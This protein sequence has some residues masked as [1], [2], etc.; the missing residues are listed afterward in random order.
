MEKMIRVTFK[1]NF[2]YSKL[3]FKFQNDLSRDCVKI[4]QNEN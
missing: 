2:F 3:N 1:K 4:V